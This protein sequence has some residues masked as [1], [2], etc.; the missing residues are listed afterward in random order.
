MLMAMLIAAL[1]IKAE[2]PAEGSFGPIIDALAAE[3]SIPTYREVRAHKA[4]GLKVPPVKA[5]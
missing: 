3:T 4:V 1:D 2:I 5:R